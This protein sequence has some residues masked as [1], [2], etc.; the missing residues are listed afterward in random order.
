MGG[1]EGGRKEGGEEGCL[2]GKDTLPLPVRLLTY[3]YW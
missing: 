3:R 1:G 2:Y